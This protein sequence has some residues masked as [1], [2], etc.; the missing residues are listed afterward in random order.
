MLAGREGDPSAPEFAPLRG[1]DFELAVMAEAAAA[2]WAVGGGRAA[3]VVGGHFA[4]RGMDQTVERTASKGSESGHTAQDS[5]ALMSDMY[6]EHRDGVILG[7]EPGVSA[8]LVLE[9]PADLQG[10]FGES[11]GLLGSTEFGGA[12]NRQGRVILPF[13]EAWDTDASWISGPFGSASIRAASCIGLGV[14]C[15]VP[16]GSTPA[17]V[18]S[19][20]GQELGYAGFAPP[21]LMDAGAHCSLGRIAVRQAVGLVPVSSLLPMVDAGVPLSTGGSLFEGLRRLVRV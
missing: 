17:F 4:G 21:L 8:A 15:E 19:P 10:S 1:T 7:W 16:S 14:V 6:E 18:R 12:L 3:F 13:G 11:E 2:L 5:A 9:K 20:L